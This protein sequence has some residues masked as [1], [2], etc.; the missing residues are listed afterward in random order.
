MFGFGRR[1]TRVAPAPPAPVAHT[2]VEEFTPPEDEDEIEFASGLVRE[3]ID[4]HLMRRL[5]HPDDLDS[6]L[7]PRPSPQDA[8]AR[9]RRRPPPRRAL[10]PISEVMP[11]GQ[12]FRGF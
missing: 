6:L 9:P 2:Q 12:W 11:C 10:E 7:P 5:Q 1:H 8:A 3:V 4:S